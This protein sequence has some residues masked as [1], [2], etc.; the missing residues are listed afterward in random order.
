VGEPGGEARI[1]GKAARRRRAK[2]FFSNVVLVLVATAMPCLA[3]ELILRLLSPSADTPGLFVETPSEIEWAG[4]PDARG[5]FG[6]VPV[7]FNHFGL[8]DRERS[9]KRTPGA[10][11]I[12]ALGDSVTF[13]LGVATEEAFPRVTENLLNAARPDG[14]ASVEVLNFGVPGYNTLHELAQLRAL[15]LAFEP[16]LVVVGFLYNDLEIS[17][18]QRLRLERGSTPEQPGGASFARRIKSGLNAGIT[19]LKKHSL[20]V[21][22]ITPRLGLVLRPLGI[23]GLGQVGE[24]KDQFVDANPDWRRVR[25]ALLEMKRLCEARGIQLVVMIIPAMA[26]FTD[27]GYPIKE[28]HEAVAAFCRAHSIGYLDLLPA[29]WGQDGTRLWISL[30]D[31]HPDARGH[32][33]MAQALASFLTPLLRQAPLAAKDRAS[34]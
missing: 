33:I 34:R 24:I 1:D 15:G 14:L 18:P 17:G 16:D 29:F 25:A 20:F 5:L 9:M 12:L 30:T 10:I 19:V 3:A 6:G 21:A 7:A 2:L 31:G 26:R 13:G 28:Y 32:R 4:R 8:R 11:R 23:K 27:S 22:W